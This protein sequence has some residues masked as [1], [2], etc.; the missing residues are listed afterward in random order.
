MK[1]IYMVLDFFNS[2]R[3][4]PPYLCNFSDKV[5]FSEAEGKWAPLCSV[6]FMYQT[7]LEKK[8]NNSSGYNWVLF[9]RKVT[10]C[11]SGVAI[12]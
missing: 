2:S 7:T 10:I 6:H 8:K 5:I 1:F 9:D 3:P 11:N 12:F 4:T